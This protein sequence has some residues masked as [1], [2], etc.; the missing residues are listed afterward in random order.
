V[1]NS[2][3]IRR[4]FGLMTVALLAVAVAGCAAGAKL[5]TP[6]HPEASTTTTNVVVLEAGG[7]TVTPSID[8]QDAQQVRVSV[9]GFLPNR[10]FYLSECLSP[11]ELTALG[12]GAQLA[13]QPF[14]LSDASGNGSTTFTVHSAASSGAHIPTVE[15]CTGECVIV[16]TAGVSEAFYSAPITFAP[17]TA[18]APG[19]PRCKNQQITV[20]D[21][22]GGAGLGHEDQ[23]LVFTN[24]SGSACSLSGY[25]G[26]AGLTPSEAQ[27]VQADRTFSG[28]LGGLLPGVTA[29]PVVSLA[30]A[31]TA[32]AVAEGTDNPSG[33]QPC[34]HYP[35]LLITPPDLTEQVRVQVTDLGTQGFPGCSGIEV[36]PVVPG[37]SG[38]SPGF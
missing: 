29:L 34:P 14:G 15:A 32:S 38:S 6:P 22:G 21:T 7:L 25:P 18:T 9:K 24:D 33:S 4:S 28:Y 3:V 27:A 13:A 30:P 23:V 1:S 36:H 11:T 26:V 10:K 35:S 8:L 16:A 19:T 12:C 17:P 31:Q 5:T 20:T 2:D 37:S